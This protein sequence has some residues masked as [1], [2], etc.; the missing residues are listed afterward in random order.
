MSLNERDVMILR[1]TER[2]T[3][4]ITSAGYLVIKQ[5]SDAPGYEESIALSPDQSKALADYI[6]ANVEKQ[7]AG[8]RTPWLSAD[9]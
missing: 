5:E 8:W 9:L 1:P 3:V 2:T 7:E 4:G 6:L